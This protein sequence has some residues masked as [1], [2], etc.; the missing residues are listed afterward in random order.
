MLMKKML[1]KSQ[2]LVLLVIFIIG[3]SNS[4]HRSKLRINN[5]LKFH[6][7]KYNNIDITNSLNGETNT[8]FHLPDNIVPVEYH[9]KIL[10]Y[11]EEKNFTFVSEIKILLYIHKATNKIILNSLN[12]NFNESSTAVSTTTVNSDGLTEKIN[13]TEVKLDYNAEQAII[14]TDTFLKTANEYNLVINYTGYISENMWGFYRSWYT[15]K[16]DELR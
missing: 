10:P 8:S 4:H 5:R 15:T 9:I 11:F 16:N 7:N 1:L 3:F 13:V 2:L 14:T 12:L 6:F